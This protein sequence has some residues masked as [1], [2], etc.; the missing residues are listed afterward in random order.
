MHKCDSCGLRS[1]T[2][3]FFRIEKGGLFGRDKLVCQGC[4]PYCPTQSELLNF[5][6]LKKLFAC[7]IAVPI[8]FFCINPAV[9]TIFFVMAVAAFA[10]MPLRIMCHEAGHAL[11]AIALGRHLIEVTVGSGPSWMAARVCGVV[12]AFRRY[13]Y[14][15]GRTQ[16]FYMCDRAGRLADAVIVIAGPAANAACAVLLFWQCDV[17]LRAKTFG[18]EVAAAALAGFALGQVFTAIVNLI[19]LRSG[20]GQHETDG[21]L[22]LGV[23]FGRKEQ[24]DVDHLSRSLIFGLMETRRFDEAA[25]AA[26]SA[27]KSSAY[28]ILFIARALHCISRGFGDEAAVSCYLEHAAEVERSIANNSEV[29]LQWLPW[30]QANIAWSA[31]KAKRADLSDL[32]ERFSFAALEAVPEAPE[33]KG[34]RGAWL[35][36]NGHY[37]DGLALLTE[38]VRSVSDSL[39]KADFC[40]FLVRGWK[41]LGNSHCLRGYE[42]LREHLM[43]QQSSAIVFTPISA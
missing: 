25:N 13:F 40:S 14:T 22:L 42:E 32:I 28:P 39:D 10:S 2:K 36:E 1:T 23:L 37:N 30:L 7:C 19:P 29:D 43:A 27:A 26:L 21:R 20:D 38:A 9:G 16:Y 3:D 35:I 15:G 6:L 12:I 17:M 33:M 34:T 24:L 11:M 31:I 18:A 41:A 5:D 8:G 4:A